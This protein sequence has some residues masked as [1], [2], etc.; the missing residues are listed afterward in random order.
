MQDFIVAARKARPRWGPRMLRNW[1]VDRH[2]G[3]QF[4]S[5]SSC[6]SIL[7]RN[8]LTVPRARGRRRMPALGEPFAPAIAP[9]S[10]WCMDFKG[11]FK[12]ADGDKCLPMTI[13]DAFSRY[14][15]RRTLKLGAASTPEAN[16]RAQQRAF[17]L[18]RRR[19]NEERPHAAIG[20]RTPSSLYVPSVRCYPCGLIQPHTLG[21][22]Q[23]LEVDRHGFIRWNRQRIFVSAAL[24]CEKLT[25][26]PDG[27]TQWAVHFGRILLGHFDD[28]NLERGFCGHPRPRK[29]HYLDLQNSEA[30]TPA[31]HRG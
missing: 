24:A 5:V 18:F 15:L 22:G 26:M 31:A 4:P 25:V 21:L 8:G 27:Y 28:Q 10:V 17:D 2:P 13:L 11:H 14:N 29:S 6:A 19:Y 9:N 30:D 1:L 7:K 3:R 12:T 16:A 23:V 20:D